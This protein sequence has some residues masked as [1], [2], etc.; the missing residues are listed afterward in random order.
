[1]GWPEYSSPFKWAMGRQS[2]Q[3]ARQSSRITTHGWSASVCYDRLLWGGTS[4]RTPPALTWHSSGSVRLYLG[5][6]TTEQT[7]HSNGSWL[8]EPTVALLH[9]GV[10]CIRRSVRLC[11]DAVPWATRYRISRRAF[12]GKPDALRT[13]TLLRVALVC[14]A[15]FQKK[16]SALPV[17]PAVHAIHKLLVK[18]FERA[19]WSS[20][21]GQVEA[22]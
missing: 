3:D 16:F 11:V 5:P 14:P 4:E 20:L 6:G 2:G 15:S 17:V 12:G 22:N 21:L 8:T 9:Q 18:L 1:M 13:S 10:E 7:S 19:A